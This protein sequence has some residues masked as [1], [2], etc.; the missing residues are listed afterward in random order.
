MYREG[1][2]RKN[3]FPINLIVDNGVVLVIGGGQ[4]GRRKV[5]Q[6]LEA[7]A[8][9]EL[10]CPDAVDEL[11][12]WAGEGR[13][14]WTKRP[15]RAGDVAGHL[16]VFACTDDKHLNRAILDEARAVHV[17]C[18]CADGN[19]SDGDFTTPA[20]V[21][22][23]DMLVSV[24]TSG[25]SC[26][27]ARDF[28]DEIASMLAERKNLELV[29]LGTSDALLPSRKRA[30]F[31]L[32]AEERTAVGRLIG[33][34]RG[35]HEFLILNTCN[36]VEIAAVASPEPEVVDV[37]KRLTALNRLRDEEYFCIKGYEAFRHLVRVT[38]GLES[39]LLGEFHIVSQVKDALDEA[40]ANG[41]SGPAIRTIGAETMRVSKA[42]RHEVEGM[43]RVA[44]I[45]QIAVRYL[46][47]HGGL[48]PKT[49]VVVVG[50]GMVGTGVVEA[51]AKTGA[52]VTW[53]YHVH[54]P[55]F[56]HTVQLADL[57][58]VLA[59]ADIVVSA[60]DAS[61]PVVTQDMRAAVADRNVLFV[62]LG[63]PRNI[64]PFYDDWGHGVTV[65][66]LDDLKL[67]HR[68]K[69]GVLNEVLAKADAV[70]RSEYR[71]PA[72]A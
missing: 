61:N 67:W 19:W 13:I 72:G 26:T 47:V 63:V 34:V 15:F 44:E 6:L 29:V 1:R 35:V 9:V 12:A 14:R 18:C 37:L 50:T 4:V 22:S 53:A 46:S 7:G 28:R 25:Q 11:S 3:T 56:P 55:D 66:D 51:L 52:Q 30:P 21:R 17:P 20:I 57:P 8:E 2:P 40:E 71:A 54:K 27:A 62:D 45:D 31:H 16:M 65:A 24:S 36:R 64:D 70:I 5:R 48:D 68:V 43:L 58:G 59:T 33:R 10:I 41:W 69:T 49:H 60:V 32:P 39:S 23:G 38:S 42:V